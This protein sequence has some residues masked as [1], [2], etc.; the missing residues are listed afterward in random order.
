MEEERRR[1]GKVRREGEEGGED[2]ERL[3]VKGGGWE[4]SGGGK[5]ARRVVR[6]E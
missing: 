4:K 5:E 2:W 1:G 6:I 3:R